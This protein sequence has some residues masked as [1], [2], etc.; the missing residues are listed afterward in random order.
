MPLILKDPVGWDE[1]SLRYTDVAATLLRARLCLTG[2]ATWRGCWV[3]IS[4]WSR[5]ARW[6]MM[7]PLHWHTADRTTRMIFKGVFHPQVHIY[8]LVLWAWQRRPCSQ[9]NQR[10]ASGHR[11]RLVRKVNFIPLLW[12]QTAL[13]ERRDDVKWQSGRASC[14]AWNGMTSCSCVFVP[15]TCFFAALDICAHAPARLLSPLKDL[16]ARR[17]GVTKRVAPIFAPIADYQKRTV[18]QTWTI[19]LRDETCHGVETDRQNISSWRRSPAEPSRTS[20]F[21]IPPG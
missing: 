20:S 5:R 1:S 14:G 9:T 12:P 7:F 11:I 18:H 2:V 4:L 8:L 6:G 16:R 13:F 19:R 21:L 3:F 10:Q 15:K 17:A